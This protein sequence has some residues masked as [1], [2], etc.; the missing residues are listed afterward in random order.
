MI[1]ILLTIT[2]VWAIIDEAKQ[3]AQKHI[4]DAIAQAN[5]KVAEIT[6]EA[7]ENGHKIGYEEGQEAIKKD[8]IEQI[9]NV[10]KFAKSEFEIKIPANSQ[11]KV[12]YF[13]PYTSFDNIRVE[14][15]IKKKL[16]RIAFSIEKPFFVVV[17]DDN[18][19]EYCNVDFALDPSGEMPMVWSAHH[20]II[21]IKIQKK[22]DGAYVLY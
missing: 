8:L 18:L 21:C 15:S 16:E 1:V 3:N 12:I 6:Q 9:E 13:Y 19:L 4:D 5:A 14:N 7:R 22:Q 10:D 20:G 17:E 11:Y 2:H